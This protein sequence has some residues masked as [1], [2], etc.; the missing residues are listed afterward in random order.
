MT[1]W[2]NRY[3][4]GDMPWE[5]GEAAPPLQEV[6]KKLAVSD[7]GAGPILVPG[8]GLGHDVRALAELGL[9]VLGV[10]VSE[11]AVERAE[12]FPKVGQERYEL[13]DFLTPE[14]QVGRT[15]SGWWEHTCFCAIDPT[16]RSNYAKA[17][18]ACLVEGG[19]L[20]GVF[21][22]N[23]YDPGDDRTGP[24]HAVTVEEVEQWFSP[25]FE[26]V[27]SWVPTT[28]YPGREGREWIGLFRKS[29]QA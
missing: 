12:R 4:A 19:L 21:F 22:I 1:D 9:S 13:G 28:S 27:D 24:P 29:T 18:A 20:A 26:R 8:C 14:W 15:F 2:E 25:W 10:D 11:T 5:K 3:R 6:I 17:A 23:P 16:Q 7:W